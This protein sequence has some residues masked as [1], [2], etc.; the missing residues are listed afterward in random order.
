MNG[1]PTYETGEDLARE[2]GVAERL[3]NKWK[4]KVIKTP[5]KAP[6][7]YC[8]LRDDYIS[9]IIE[10][11]VRN[12]ASTKYPTYMLS[13]DNVIQCALHSGTIRCPFIVVVQFTDK[14]LHWVLHNPD[15]DFA[16]VRA[17]IGGRTDRG[18]AFDVEPV[19]HI[20]MRKFVE[21]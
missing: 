18:D 4:C 20:P 9:A 5:P 11:K 13:V 16:D 21:V 14:L 15:E 6:Y 7:D 8:A 3:S 1:R 10:I 12:N 17:K 19:L 2:A